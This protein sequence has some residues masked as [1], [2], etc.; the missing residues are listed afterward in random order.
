MTLQEAMS[1]AGSPILN[2]VMYSIPANLLNKGSEQFTTES[3]NAL[4]KT[5]EEYARKVS[6]SARIKEVRE[7]N[8][9]C[10][11]FF[12]FENWKACRLERVFDNTEMDILLLKEL[13]GGS[14]ALRYRK[15]Q[16]QRAEQFGMSKNA[17]QMRIHALEQGKEI[18]G[19]RVKIEIDGRGR[20]A[21]D[22]TIHPIFCALNL[23][24]A[25]FLTVELRKT[26]KGTPF[27]Q[28]ANDI[29]ADIYKQ[30]S[31]YAQDRLR[32]QIEEAGLGFEQ[33]SI[34]ELIDLRKES[35]DAIYFLKSGKACVL[36]MMNGDRYS[37]RIR[38]GA[39]GL[40]LE[41]SEGNRIALPEDPENYTLS[42][43]EP[44]NT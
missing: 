27:E 20:T 37:G 4:R 18:L 36:Q 1:S 8:D 29:S 30:L 43:F 33:S 24:E 12:N 16:E 40:E 9:F 13:Q 42:V 21:Y 2:K 28:L 10:D 17:M 6:F 31:G 39:S 32:Q 11:G 34:D 38:T 19:H 14:D 23:K 35:R 7:I 25:Y 5:F 41:D 22:N 44:N 15:T 26:F 3:R